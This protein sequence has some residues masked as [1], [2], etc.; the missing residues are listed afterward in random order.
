MEAAA[1]AAF[2]QFSLQASANEPIDLLNFAPS[3]AWLGVFPTGYV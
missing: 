3:A 2:A 1:S